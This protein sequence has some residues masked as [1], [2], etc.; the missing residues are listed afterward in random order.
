MRPPI[1]DRASSTV[2]RLPARE[3]S[4]AAASPA[5]PAPMT[6]TSTGSWA[7][8]RRSGVP[9]PGARWIGSALERI[10][11][12]EEIEQPLGRLLRR[13]I[14]VLRERPQERLQGTDGFPEILERPPQRGHRIDPGEH[15]VPPRRRDQ[16]PDGGEVIQDG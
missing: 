16:P 2:T 8:S 14:L 4:D 6:R 11:P 10:F 7:I 5:A 1:R 12:A 15:V 3:S 13:R 9:D